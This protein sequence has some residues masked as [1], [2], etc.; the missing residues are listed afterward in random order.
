MPLT[1]YERTKKFTIH[2]TTDSA[3]Y[4]T[5][6]LR[7]AG[8]SQYQIGTC[9]LTTQSLTVAQPPSPSATTT[10]N[11]SIALCSPSGYIYD[12]TSILEYL[13]RQTQHIKQQQ[14]QLEER[15]HQT[16]QEQIIHEANRKKRHM[17]QLED[18]RRVIIPQSS[19]LQTE[20]ATAIQDLHRV[21]YWLST[22]QP[23]VD[24]A[25]AAATNTKTFN[26]SAAMIPAITTSTTTTTTTILLAL[27]NGDDGGEEATANTAPND[28]SLPT[29]IIVNA[30]STTAVT[31]TATTR[32]TPTTS[33]ERPKSPMTGQPF[34]RR[35]L[36]PIRLEWTTTTT[37][38]STNATPQVKCAISDR[39]ISNGAPVVAYWTTK[40]P[41]LYNNSTNNNNSDTVAKENNEHHVGVMVLQSVYEKELQLSLRPTSTATTGSDDAPPLTRNGTKQSS[42]SPLSNRCP[43]TDRIIRHVRILQRSGTSY[44]GSGQSVMSAQQYKP[45]IT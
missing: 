30:G 10:T 41:Y 14:Q 33:P 8:H 5:T 15:N 12:E 21:S 2:S 19:R 32:P 28:A 22:A 38:T 43:L 35:D 17:E 11:A 26:P 25:A 20:Q 44:A 24:T 31:A 37:T 27:T 4:G 1:H 9:A 7:L 42:A 16:K 40:K 36:W 34:Q 3:D 23:V 39:I 45:T 6:S 13:L 29:D 18:S